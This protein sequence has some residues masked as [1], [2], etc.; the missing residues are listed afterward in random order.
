MSNNQKK[1]YMPHVVN[2]QIAYA[3]RELRHNKSV[4][5]SCQDCEKD[6]VF[7]QLSSF[8]NSSH[9]VMKTV[10]KPNSSE[11]FVEFIETF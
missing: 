3:A 6:S 4:T 8:S 10:N 11:V 9:I 2:W 1:G 5:L 7:E